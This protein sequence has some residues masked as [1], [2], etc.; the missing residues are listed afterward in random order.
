MDDLTS[1]R[2]RRAPTHP[3]AIWRDD[4]LP[5]RGLTAAGAVRDLGVSRQA[6]HGVL[7]R[8]NPWAARP[9]MALRF[10]SLCGGDALAGLWLRMQ[11]AY[12]LWQASERVV[13]DEIPIR[14]A[15]TT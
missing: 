1:A 8:E 7:R 11:A 13:L 10:A 2:P 3:G 9:E 4:V 5:A 15:A 6:L 14:A 12:A